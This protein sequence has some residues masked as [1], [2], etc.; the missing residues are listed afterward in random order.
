[1]GQEQKP[2]IEAFAEHVLPRLREG[3]S[4]EVTA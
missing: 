1:V 3:S 4:R 2:F